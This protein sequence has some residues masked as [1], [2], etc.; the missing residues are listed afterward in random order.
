M[1]AFKNSSFVASSMKLSRSTSDT[2]RPFTLLVARGVNTARPIGAAASSMTAALSI[3]RTSPNSANCPAVCAAISVPAPPATSIP[4]P[5]PISVALCATFST[6]A[7]LNIPSANAFR[8]TCFTPAC[9]NPPVRAPNTY[10]DPPLPVMLA[11]ILRRVS[12][13]LIISRTRVGLMSNLVSSPR[14]LPSLRATSSRRISILVEAPSTTAPRALIPP[15]TEPLMAPAVAVT[16]AS[17]SAVAPKA[18][19]APAPTPAPAAPS[20]L[21][22]SFS[23]VASIPTPEET[24]LASDTSASCKTTAISSKM[25]FA[26]SS[27]RWCSCSL[28]RS[29]PSSIPFRLDERSSASCWVISLPKAVR[30]ISS[31]LAPV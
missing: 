22:V 11:L 1:L 20:P 16:G 17:G 29:A 27:L 10:R 2:M 18:A 24:M 23:R 8:P 19:P 25:P 30:K 3:P 4:V 21:P 12:S 9:T 31:A 14:C 6:P 5:T 26:F 28:L 13:S 7:F 15:Y